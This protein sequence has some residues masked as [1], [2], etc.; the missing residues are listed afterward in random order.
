MLRVLLPRAVEHEVGLRLPAP[1]HGEVIDR[2]GSD[3]V[4]MEAFPGLRRRGGIVLVRL[5]R[6]CGEEAAAVLAER[7]FQRH[8]DA[9]PAVVIQFD[10]GQVGERRLDRGKRSGLTVPMG[11]MTLQ[12]SAVA[13]EAV[14]PQVWRQERVRLLQEGAGRRLADLRKL[15]DVE[16]GQ[17]LLGPSIGSARV[18]MI[19][20]GEEL[21]PK[22]QHLQ[23]MSLDP[24]ER[25]RR[26][27]WLTMDGSPRFGTMR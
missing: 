27:I 12:R 3:T 6:P 21:L 7:A 20:I 5:R 24:S 14:L 11:G 8:A 15:R 17:P 22:A 16:I 1:L 26:A 2:S 9:H 25:L 23:R 18:R 4:R 13:V 19:G 10:V